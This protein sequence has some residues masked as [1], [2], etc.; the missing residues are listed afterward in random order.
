MRSGP[1]KSQSWVVL[2]SN[3]RCKLLLVFFLFTACTPRGMSQDHAAITGTVLDATEAPIQGAEI[4]FRSVSG[5]TVTGTDEKGNFRLEG[6]ELGGTLLVSFPGFST[7]TRELRARTSVENL[8]IVM[9]PA[10]GLQRIEV[11]GRPYS[12]GAH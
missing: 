5:I 8:R 9:I 12:R 4:Q 7:V 10:A 2:C 11:Q 3:R 1:K 6:I